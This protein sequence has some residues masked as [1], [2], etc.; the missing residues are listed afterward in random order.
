MNKKHGFTL[1]EM[2]TVVL[3]VGVLTAVALPQYSRA[4]KKSRA[5][6]AIA[7]LRVIHDSGERLATEFGYRNFQAFSSAE[8]SKATFNRMDMFDQNTIKCAFTA[9]TMTCDHY[10]YYLNQGK[11]YITAEN[12]NS[13]HSGETGVK[14]YLSR[15]DIPVVTCSGDEDLCELY[16]LDYVAEKE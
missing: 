15:T 16:N 13:N 4:I 8:A 11:N 5:T 14:F 1:M 12:I 2:L 7:M 3:I 9:T 10:K 6:E